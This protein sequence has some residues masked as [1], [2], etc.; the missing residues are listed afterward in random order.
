MAGILVEGKLQYDQWEPAEGE[1]RSRLRVRAMRVQFLARARAE[2]GA[3]DSAAAPVAAVTSVAVTVTSTLPTWA[4][5][6]VPE[7]VRVAG[8]NISQSGRLLAL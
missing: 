1:K 2:Q 4:F 7:N 5:S 8:V 6:G 3:P